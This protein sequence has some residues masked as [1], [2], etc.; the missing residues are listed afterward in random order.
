M[1][2]ID[3]TGRVALVTGASRG[4][5]RAMALELGKAGAHVIATARTTGALEEVDDLIRAAGGSSTLVPLDLM[6]SDGIEQLGAIVEERWGKLD[7]LLANAGQLGVLTPAAQIKAK[8]WNEVIGVNLLAPARMIRAFE[9]LLL[10]S[11][12]GG[13]AVFISSGAATSRRAFWAP[14][15]ASKAGLDALV[16]SWADEHNNNP[17]QINLVYPGAVRTVMRAKAFPGEDA[18]S[19]P[20][21]ATLWPLIAELVSDDCQRHREIV[22]A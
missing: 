19:L 12:T 5:G 7:I 14:Y 22:K 11:D 2:A 15:A 9:A 17:L 6:S 20:E 21:P 10:K 8:T 16:Q 4:I 13:R 18:N 3:L 1:T